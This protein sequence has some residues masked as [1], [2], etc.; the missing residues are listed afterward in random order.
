MFGFIFGTACLVGLYWVVR[1]HRGPWAFGRR[2]VLRSVFERLDTTPGQEKVIRD[3][4]DDFLKT[5]AGAR[6]SA[7]E[8]RKEIASAVRKDYFDET[9][10]GELFARQDDVIETLRKEVVGTLGRVHATLDEAQRERLGDL[11]EKGA[12]GGFRPRHRACA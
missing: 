8:W 11:L 7:R 1:R 5:A 9:L 2:A 6:E 4:V 12:G 3:A 10:L